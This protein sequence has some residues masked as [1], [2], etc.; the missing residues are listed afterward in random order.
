VGLTNIETIAQQ[1][2]VMASEGVRTSTY[3]LGHD[4]NEELMAAMARKGRGNAYY[5]SCLD[6][7]RI[8]RRI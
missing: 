6:D 1:C 3:G 7:A 2:G 5:G 4:F 8:A